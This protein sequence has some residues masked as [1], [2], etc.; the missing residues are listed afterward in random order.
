MKIFIPPPPVSVFIHLLHDNTLTEDNRDKLIQIAERYGAPL[1]FYNVEELCAERMEKIKEFFPNIFDDRHSIAT[2]YRFFIPHIFPQEI[3]KVLYLDSDIIVNLDIKEFWQIELGDKPF[4]SVP[5][6]YQIS[7]KSD[8][9][10]TKKKSITICRDGVVNVE[11]YFNAGVMII[12]LKVLR[13]EETTIL[14][15]M[16]FIS[17][18]PQFTFLDQ[19]ILNY[20]FSTTYLKL[21]VK[22]NRFVLYARRENEWPIQEKLYHYAASRI[23]FVMDSRDPFN[24]LF[25]KYFIKTPWIDDDTKAALSG[26]IPSRK[27]YPVSVIVPLYNEEEYIGECL[28]SLLAQTFQAFEVIVVDDC[29]TDNSVK[30]VE[31]YAPKFNGRLRLTKTKKN[32]G[33]GGY[34]PRNIGLKLACG[35]YIYVLDADDLILGNALETFY[36]AAILYDADIVYT[37]TCYFL[38][39]PN[40]I[41]LYKDGISR[42]IPNINTEL[43]IDDPIQ[44]LNRLFSENATGEFNTIQT[45]FCRRE[46]LLANRLF[47]PQIARSGDFLW[48]A[49]AY[50]YVKRFLR[51]STPLCL[52]RRYNENSITRTVREPQ[53]QILFWFVGFVEFAKSLYDLNKENEIWAENLDYALAMLKKNLLW[54]LD[55]TDYA[56]K[57]LVSEEIFK[58]LYSKFS[59]NFFDSAALLLPFF[60]SVIDGLIKTNTYYSEIFNKFKPYFTARMDV[61]LISKRQCNFQVLNISDEKATIEKPAWFQKK[62]IG[63]VISSCVGKL[64]F[65]AKADTNGQIRIQLKSLDIRNPENR[66]KR[67]PYWIDYTRLVVNGT[68]V[69]DTITPV[70]HDKDYSYDINVKADEEIKIEVEWLPHRDTR[71]DVA[72]VVAKIPDNNAE[73]LRE[74]EALISELRTALSNEKKTAD[75]QRAL[76]SEL[77]TALDNEK[78]AHN[79][80]V[81]LISKFKDYFTARVDIKLMSTEGDFKILSVSDSEVKITQPVWMQKD[82]TAYIIISYVGELEFVAYASVDGQICLWLR[83]LDM[84][85]PEDNSKRIPYWIDY[86]RLVIN[87]KTMFDKLTPIWHDKPY[88]CNVNVKANEKIKIK[89]EWLPHRSDT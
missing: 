71:N 51:I 25:M 61:N 79:S 30:I 36:S 10:E 76:V 77:P 60:F 80:D 1:K 28:D 13:K 87:D 55:R 23:C 57:K 3:E 69:F 67:I 27:N 54:S 7:N 39:A 14:A 24:Q 15:G 21:P 2:F 89:V 63:Y 42:K 64:E 35:D 58:V 88:R 20:C 16:K 68:T 50:C 18:H 59:Q 86:T 11:D 53:E 22:F 52:R 84:R 62:G 33:G 31:E 78:Q 47:F 73:K 56:R 74:Y 75:E 19:D 41:M 9:I 43:T 4:G 32:S 12:N 46:F 48:I 37:K 65:V 38:N 83:G 70:W 85:D 81:A 29:S 40:D 17:E 6:F 66:K 44:N 72:E 82:G 49:N 5:E 26:A 45:T 8:A 34:V